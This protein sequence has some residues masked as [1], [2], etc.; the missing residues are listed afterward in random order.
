MKLA[1]YLLSK[2]FTRLFSYNT[3]FCKVKTKQKKIIYKNSNNN[4]ISIT[5]IIIII[6]NAFISQIIKI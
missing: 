6:L 3:D 1:L 2:S 5:K 4:A